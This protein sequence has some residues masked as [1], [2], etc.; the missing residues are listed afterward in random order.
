[1]VLAAHR[2]ATRGGG[3]PDSDHIGT[4]P[5]HRSRLVLNRARERLWKSVRLR[6]ISLQAAL[7]AIQMLGMLNIGTAS[8]KPLIDDAFSIA[9][10][11]DRT[12]YDAVYVILAVASGRTLLTADERLVNALGTRFPVQ[13][14]GAILIGR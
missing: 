8:T 5:T 3:D 10:A 7:D 11:F 9:V 4:D 6:R 2:R 13:W 14:L 1:M 12:V